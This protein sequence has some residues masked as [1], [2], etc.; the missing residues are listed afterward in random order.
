MYS[1]CGDKR[2]NCGQ[3]GKKEIEMAKWRG[4]SGVTVIH[5]CAKLI[6]G[7]PNTIIS[8]KLDFNLG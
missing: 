6:Q 2:N 1:T 3:D 7:Y 8:L 5:Y 4:F